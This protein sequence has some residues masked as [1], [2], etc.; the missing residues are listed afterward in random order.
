MV[1]AASESALI[2]AS[3]VA[4]VDGAAESIGDVA[5]VVVGQGGG[6]VDS[7]SDGVDVRGE[8]HDAIM[9]S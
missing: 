6:V 9:T 8:V 5:G 7:G 1:S 3:R 4:D 2:R